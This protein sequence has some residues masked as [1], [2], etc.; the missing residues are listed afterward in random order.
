[1]KKDNKKEKAFRKRPWLWLCLVVVLYG[2]WELLG[3]LTARILYLFLKAPVLTAGQAASIGIIGGAD[4]PTAIFITTPG[5]VHWIVPLVF[6]FAGG[7]ASCIC[8]NRIKNERKA[9]NDLRLLY[10]LF[11]DCTFEEYYVLGEKLI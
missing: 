4:G 7:R 5:W 8:G 11:K 1:M 2:L 10:I 3:N 9:K 6:L